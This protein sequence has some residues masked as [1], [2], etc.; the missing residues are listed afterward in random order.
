MEERRD[1]F[2]EL[3][4]FLGALSCHGLV[5]LC[6]DLNARLHRRRPGEETALGEHIF[7]NPHAQ[8]NP[9]SN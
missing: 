8:H 7:G 2:Q 5:F 6:G 1:F 4:R 9:V 3:D